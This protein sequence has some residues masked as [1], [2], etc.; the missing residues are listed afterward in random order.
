LR[1]A[2]GPTLGV[3]FDP[4]HLIWMGGDPV[5]AIEA[6]DDCIYHVHGKDSRIEAQAKIN[7]LLDVKHATPARGRAWNFVSLGRGKSADAWRDIIRALR[8]VG[9][10]DTIS[11]ENEDYSLSSDEAVSVS[12]ATLRLCID[13]AAKDH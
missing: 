1:E 6:L 5:S 11:I 9:Y 7:G 12:I 3:N 8:A 4:S 10:D 2:V 13:E